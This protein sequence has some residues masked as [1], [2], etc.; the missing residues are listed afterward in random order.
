MWACKVLVNLAQCHMREQLFIMW[1][2]YAKG[3]LHQTTW[4]CNKRDVPCMVIVNL[5]QCHMRE[6]LFIM[7]CV[8]AKGLLD[9]VTWGCMEFEATLPNASCR[10]NYSGCGVC[11]Q[12]FLHQE[13]WVWKKQQ[14]C[15]MQ[16]CLLKAFFSNQLNLGQTCPLLFCQLTRW[17]TTCRLQGP[18]FI[19]W[20][21]IGSYR[22]W[23][24]WAL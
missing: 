1:C 23:L 15:S 14:T 24:Q 9:E 2:V 13:V 6:Q 3:F 16:L 8:Y 18:L 4:G 10:G 22:C 11:I 17:P 7:W 12:R 21:C 19:M 20:S 5:A